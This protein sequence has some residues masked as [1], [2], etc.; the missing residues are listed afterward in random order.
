MTTT[1]MTMIQDWVW[2]TCLDD[3]I[4]DDFEDKG[5]PKDLEKIHQDL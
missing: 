5:I 4:E 3:D 2:M 1:A